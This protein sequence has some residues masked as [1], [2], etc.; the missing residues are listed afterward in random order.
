MPKYN[1]LVGPGVKYSL[2]VIKH[3]R[4]VLATGPAASFK[5]QA[6][7]SERLTRYPIYCRIKTERK[8]M[9][10]QKQYNEMLDSFNDEDWKNIRRRMEEKLPETK[11]WSEKLFR[12]YT[13]AVVRS[14]FRKEGLN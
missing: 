1:L 4:W 9:I 7:S 5:R 8:H 13:T 6:S 10:T 3:N 11:L 2:A 14:G 12:N